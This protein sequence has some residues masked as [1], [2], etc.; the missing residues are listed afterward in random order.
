MGVFSSSLRAYVA[1]SHAHPI[2]DHRAFKVQQLDHVFVWIDFTGLSSPSHK[3]KSP[4]KFSPIEMS[5][6]T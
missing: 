2:M 4:S 1:S 5:A 6:Q 3:E